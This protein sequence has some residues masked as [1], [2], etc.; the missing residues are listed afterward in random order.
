[1]MKPPSCDI[2]AAALAELNGWHLG[3]EGASW[4]LRVQRHDFAV[5]DWPAFPLSWPRRWPGL[6]FKNGRSFGERSSPSPNV[7]PGG[8]LP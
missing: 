1:M 3:P 6:D 8:S 4:P 7:R 2:D 5:L